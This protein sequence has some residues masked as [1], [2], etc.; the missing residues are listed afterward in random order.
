MGIPGAPAV[1]TFYAIVLLMLLAVV[2]VFAV[3]NQQAVSVRFLNWS[4]STSKALLVVGAYVL[5]MMSGATVVGLF[6]R[7]LRRVADRP[8][9]GRR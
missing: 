9:T 1:R 8:A 3:E 6:N 5:G 7:L 4:M 2:L